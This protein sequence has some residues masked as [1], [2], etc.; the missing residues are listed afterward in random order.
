MSTFEKKSKASVWEYNFALAPLQ[1]SL[2]SKKKLTPIER[3]SKSPKSKSNF[4]LMQNCLS[5]K[6]SIKFF[7]TKWKKDFYPKEKQLPLKGN[8][9]LYKNKSVSIS[10]Q[11]LKPFKGKLLSFYGKIGCISYQNFHFYQSRYGLEEN[12]DSN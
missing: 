6:L 9:T 10:N 1:I 12:M 7:D 2:Q 3:R 11:N 4:S 8:E 5:Q